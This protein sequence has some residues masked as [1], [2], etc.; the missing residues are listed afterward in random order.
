MTRQDIIEQANINTERKWEKYGLARP[1]LVVMQDFCSRNRYWW[2]QCSTQFSTVAGTPTYDLSQIATSPSLGQQEI[3]VEEV[4]SIG[5]V[6]VGQN[7]PV[8][9]LTPVF[10]PQT[11]N[12][13]INGIN[14][15]GQAAN[16]RPSR[17]TFDANDYKIIRIDAPDGVYKLQTTFWG[18]PDFQIDSPNNFVPLIPPWHHKALIVGLEAYIWKRIYGPLNPRAAT[19]KQEYEEHI[20]LAQARPRFTTN[21]TQTFTQSESAVRSTS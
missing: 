10:D 4:M 6:Q 15:N 1:L 12:E 18:M 17:Y 13:M 9:E 20:L 5:I 3:A 19:A 8:D 16:T 7:P 21:Y 14:V 11:L 2:R